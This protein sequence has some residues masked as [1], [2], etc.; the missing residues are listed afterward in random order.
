MTSRI[1]VIEDNQNLAL[2]LRVNLED[3][4]YEVQL[5]RTLAD[6]FGRLR[7][8]RPD[9]VVLDLTLPDGNGLD[10][11]RRIRATG[12]TTLVLVLTAT[13]Q[14]S[15]KVRGL[16]DG[17]DDY[18]TKP[19]DLD[20]LLVR[21]EVLLRRIPATSVAGKEG[22]Q[23]KTLPIG[24]QIG[25]VYIDTR[26]HTAHKHG[27]ELRF[28]RIEFELLL[29]LLRHEGAVVSRAELMREVWGYDEE[30]QSRTLDTHVFSLRRRIEPDPNRPAYLKTVWG[31]GYRLAYQ[32]PA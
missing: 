18:V 17:A 16:R 28:S 23:S 27:E 1:L 7:Q 8:F 32:V 25:D 9:L 11:L 21:I 6:G 22:H 5:A 3:H 15:V 4:G 26:L 13:A 14:Q 20:E 29:T 24:V 30:V 2:G 31:I 12:D 10:L 19:F